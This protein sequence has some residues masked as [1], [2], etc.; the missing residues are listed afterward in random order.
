MYFIC[1]STLFY[2][3]LTSL[4][5]SLYYTLLEQKLYIVEWNL[6]LFNFIPELKFYMYFDYM[7]NLFMLVIT[8][9]S[10][11][12]FMYS[13]HYMASDKNKVKFLIL[14]FIFILSMYM[15]VINLNFFIILMGWDGLGVSSYFLVLHYQTSTSKYSGL[16]T[17][18]TNRMGDI[19]MIFCM[20]FL[21]NMNTFD[22]MTINN[23]TKFNN[24][25]LLLLVSSVF[26][27]SAQFPFSVW[28]PLAMAAPTPISSLV[29]SSTLVT[30]GIYLLIRFNKMFTLNNNFMLNIILMSCLTS[31]LAGLSALA[32][33]DIKKIIA[34]STLS[35]LSLMLI[36]MFLGKEMLCFFHIL[37]HALFKALLFLCSGVFIHETL[38]NQDLRNFPK[39]MKYN[40][41]TQN[42]FLICSLSLAGFPFLSGFYSKDL[43]LE[44]IYSMNHNIYFFFMMI[45][46]TLLTGFYS[47][48]M[49]KFSMMMKE[50]NFKMIYYNNWAPINNS[51]FWMFMM[52]LFSGA[53][54][55]W[56]LMEKLNYSYLNFKMK[57]INL[58]L[59]LLS[60][61]LYNLVSI[62]FNNKFYTLFLKMFFM[63]SLQGKSMNILNKNLIYFNSHSEKIIE[64]ILM[65]NFTKS[66]ISLNNMMFWMKF[67]FYLFIFLFSTILIIFI[68]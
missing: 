16:V 47:L 21:L 1:L 44:L 29:H 39:I 58:T 43:I 28:L 5:I 6:Y 59:C 10:A 22:L 67:F 54:L 26:T 62:N 35:Q 36:I 12:V 14:T 65:T 17:I 13:K 3:I 68:F 23:I 25:I 57:M 31:I 9:I 24:I 8:L 38:D 11:S 60:M 20:F 32:E 33:L 49:M 56:I 42:M 27:K 2:T 52:V 48:R 51:M 45:I 66:I 30:A 55:N 41:Y 37:T 63:T 34:F 50:S 19:T 53:M 40:L 4:M 18:M 46:S 64:M 61:L 7:S 15:I